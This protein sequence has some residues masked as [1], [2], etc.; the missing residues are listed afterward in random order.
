MTENEQLAFDILYSLDIAVLRRNG[1]RNY[2]FMGKA[3]SFY[4]A[5][6][7]FDPDGKPCTSPWKHSPMLEF[8]IDDVESFFE[9]GE[10]GQIDSGMWQEDGKTDANSALLAVAL[11]L[12]QAQV[13]IIRILYE[14]FRQ[15]A[16]ILRKARQQLLDNRRLAS[17]LEVFKTKSRY[18]GLTQIFNRTTFMEILQE[19]LAII[20]KKTDS[21]KIIND[22]PSLLMLDIDNFKKVNDTYGHMCGDLVLKNVGKLLQDITRKSDVVARYGGEEFVVLITRGTPEQAQ[23]IAEKIRYTIE[24]TEFSCVPS[25]SISIGCTTHLK[26]ESFE[27]LIKRADAALYDAKNSGKNK[28]C[29]R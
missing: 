18:D 12:G 19:K 2:S 24:T 7:P 22:P 1:P 10:Q 15:K 23:K 21:G 17:S 3:P 16:G 4:Q 13:I 14:D 6:F 5:F 20:R 28:V 26:D 25:L 27:D 9:S 8:F 11:T 29:V